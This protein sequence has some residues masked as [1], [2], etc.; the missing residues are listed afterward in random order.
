MDGWN[1]QRVQ[2]AIRRLKRIAIAE[3]KNNKMTAEECKK[4][5]GYWDINDLRLEIKTN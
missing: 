3:T 2:T 1:K 5:C 4:V